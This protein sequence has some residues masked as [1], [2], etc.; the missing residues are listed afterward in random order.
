M[1]DDRLFME[2]KKLEQY[3]LG[4]TNVKWLLICDNKTK[5]LESLGYP[6]FYAFDKLCGLSRKMQVAKIF[7]AELKEIKRENFIPPIAER[8]NEYIQFYYEILRDTIKKIGSLN[9]KDVDIFI[10]AVMLHEHLHIY[11]GHK[12]ETKEE[13]DIAEFEVNGWMWKHARPLQIIFAKYIPIV[14]EISEKYKF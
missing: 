9:E 14:D 10:K 5:L 6:S 7:L 11:F 2:R 3:A 4:N 8:K 13:K 12:S 1:W